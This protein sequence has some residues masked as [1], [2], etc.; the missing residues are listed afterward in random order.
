MKRTIKN[1]TATPVMLLFTAGAFVVLAVSVVLMAGE[2]LV[3]AVVSSKTTTKKGD[4]KPKAL[5]PEL[6]SVVA[7][8]SAEFSGR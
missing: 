8:P 6:L 7:S 1:L 2:S 3:S 5:S 4:R